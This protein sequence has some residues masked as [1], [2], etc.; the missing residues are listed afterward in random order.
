MKKFYTVFLLALVGIVCS[1]GASAQDDLPKVK[2]TL[3]VD[4]DNA[5]EYKV[6]YNGDWHTL[7]KGDNEIEITGYYSW[8]SVQ[9]DSVYFGPLGGFKLEGIACTDDANVQIINPL[10]GSNYF[11]VYER[12][13]GYVYNITTSDLSE[14]RT[15]TLNLNITDDATLVKVSRNGL[16][17]EVLEKGAQEFKFDP[18]TEL[19]LTFTAKNVPCYVFELDGVP[20]EF[21]NS[22]EYVVNPT[23]GQSLEI[24]TVWPADLKTNFTINI[25]EEM[26]DAVK[27]QVYPDDGW[28][29]SDVAGFVLNEANSIEAGHYYRLQFDDDGFV[30]NNVT[31]N[32]KAADTSSQRVFV[33]KDDVVVDVDASV[34]E[35]FHLIIRMGENSLASV[36]TDAYGYDYSPLQPGDNIIY[37]T[38]SY[39]SGYNSV[40]VKAGYNHKITKFECVEADHHPTLPS[41]NDLAV[42]ISPSESWNGRVYD[43]ETVSLDDLRPHSMTVNVTGSADNIT[44]RRADNSTIA[45][46]TGENTIHFADDELPLRVSRSVG[47]APIYRV[48]LNGTP[49]AYNPSTYVHSF[50]VADGDNLEIEAEW[51]ADKTVGLTINIPEEAKAAVTEIKYGSYPYTPVTEWEIGKPIEIP[52]GNQIAIGFNTSDYKLLSVKV[53]DDLIASIGSTFTFF[54]GE[55]PLDVTIDAKAYG[56]LS[57][58][59]TVDAPDQVSVHPGY[60]SDPA[61]ELVAGE[62]KEFTIDERTPNLYVKVSREYTIKSIVD[63]AT[64]Q[65][66]ELASNGSFEVKDGMDIVITSAEKQFDGKWAMWI[67]DIDDMDTTWDGNNRNCFFDEGDGNTYFSESGHTVVK[68]DTSDTQISIRIYGSLESSSNALYPYLNNEI[69]PAGWTGDYSGYYSYTGYKPQDGDVVRYYTKGNQPSLHAISFDVVGDEQGVSNDIVVV[70]DKVKTRA[71]WKDGFEILT[72]AHIALTLPEGVSGVKVSLDGAELEPDADGAYSFV[73]SADHK[74]AISS[75]S[76]IETVDACGEAGL[77]AVYNLQ[78]IKV[79]DNASA[80]DLNK[81]PAGIYIVNGGKK[82]VR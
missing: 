62:R 58:A 18:A 38:E 6:S 35:R 50:D 59:L 2:L 37:P 43:L 25:P 80:D 73:A 70:T 77:G 68:F 42:S 76:L 60:L 13:N 40:Y 63:A 82:V 61:Y 64:E 20:V 30:I 56:I 74:V 14:S 9:F 53:G 49:V 57:F 78:G 15:S 19:P 67:E 29:P 23:D 81:L 47:S 31:I 52:V 45:L 7:S 26:K 4:R 51:P 5:V 36:A 17:E 33:G 21:N 11:Y 28:S 75:T 79:L 46:S 27:L 69:L 24:S 44:F 48:V 71:D 10:G 34:K 8:G 3:N 1:F 41:S 22:R 65:P 32:G 66:I 39:W 12:S 54:V 72:G 16:A 55:E